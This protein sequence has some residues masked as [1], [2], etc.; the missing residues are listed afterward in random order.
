M[1][2]FCI[3]FSDGHRADCGLFSMMDDEILGMMQFYGAISATFLICSYCS[4]QGRMV[5]RAERASIQ[6]NKKQ[7]QGCGARKN[8]RL[9]VPNMTASVKLV[10]TPLMEIGENNGGHRAAVPRLASD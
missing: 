6:Q 1:C 9:P 4:L 3:R 10:L 5:E 2:R 8:G 7:M